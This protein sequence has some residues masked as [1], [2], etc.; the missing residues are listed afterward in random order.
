M[1]ASLPRALRHTPRLTV[2]RRTGSTNDDARALLADGPDRD[3]AVLALR[4]TRGRGRVGRRFASPRGGVYLSLALP[5]SA[6]PD[7]TALTFA[8]A[9]ATACAIEEATGVPCAIKWVNDLWLGGKKCGGILTEGVWDET[10]QPLGA[11]IGIG[12]NLKGRLPSALAPIATTLKSHTK[13]PLSVYPFAASLLSLLR[14]WLKEPASAV[15]EAYRARF[16][17]GGRRVEVQDGACRYPATVEG[18][19]EDGSLL[20][21]DD[22]GARHRLAA[23][24]V[25]LHGSPS[26]DSF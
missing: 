13:R 9:V 20:V 17:L 15:M 1:A 4:Q 23:G 21:V 26:P 11:V 12:V 6:P 19:G 7:P 10:G 3:A 14:T 18:L 25:T 2:L 5:L 8:A 22:G 16:C 24:E